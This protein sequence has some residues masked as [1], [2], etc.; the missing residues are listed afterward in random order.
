[1]LTPE[2]SNS[3]ASSQAR[4]GRSPADIIARYYDRSSK[5]WQILT[6]HGELVAERALRAAARVEHLRP[7]LAF[8]FE[9]A[10]LHD[11]GIFLTDSPEIDCHGSQ[12]YIRHGIL[13]R[14]IL[15]AFGLPRHGLVCERHV[16]VGISAEDIGRFNLPL[17]V[18]DMRPVTIEEQI[19]CYADKFFSKNGNG[20]AAGEKSVDRIVASLRR[21]GDDK[22]ERFREWVRLFG[23]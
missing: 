22:V 21:Y 17:P 5:A 15:E 1:L 8:I 19:I 10:M 2:L 18:R 11:I 4:R 12:P 16:G 6:E 13:G 3:T 23:R 14:C 9:A 20:R 7:D